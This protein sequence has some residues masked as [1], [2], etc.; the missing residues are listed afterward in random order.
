[1]SERVGRMVKEEMAFSGPVRMNGVEAVQLRGVQAVRRLEEAGRV[2]IV[3][4]HTSD[5]FV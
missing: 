2:P 5:T 4:G 3:R 1:M